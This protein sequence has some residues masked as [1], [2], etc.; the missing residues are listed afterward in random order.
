MA[1]V[2]EELIPSPIENAT[3]TKGIVDGVHRNYNIEPNEGFVLHDKGYDYLV[4]DEITGEE[5]LVLGYRRTVASCSKTQLVM[6]ENNNIVTNTREF[7]AVPEDS[8]PA[9]Q[10]FGVTEPD[11][12][13]A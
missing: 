2:Y 9:D 4:V 12:E 1:I 13:I 8:V 3:V 6:D 7:Y 11:H 5:T 10:I